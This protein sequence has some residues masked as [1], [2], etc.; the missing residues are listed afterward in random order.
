[1]CEISWIGCR[2]GTEAMATRGAVAV[3]DAIY[4]RYSSE[5][6]NP[7]SCDDQVTELR[8]ALERRGGRFDE[9]LVFRDAEVS[10]GVWQRDGLQGLLTAVEAGRVR[11]VFVEDVSRLSRDKEDAARL[12]KTFDYHGVSI[13][14]LD[15]MTYDGSVGASLAFTFQSA[16]AAQYLRDLGAKT[17][18]GLRG[19]HRAGK[20]TGGRCYGYDVVNRSIEI[21]HREAANDRRFFRLYLEGHGYAVIAQ[22]LDAL[23]VPAPRSRRRAGSG[24]MHT[25]IREMLRNPKYAGEFTFGVRK[26]QRHPMTRKRVARANHDAEVLRATRPELAIVD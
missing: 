1:M 12:E 23:G 16:G 4:A 22:K 17:R 7:R 21:N 11:R 8:Q 3:G 15:G 14:T 20:S 5:L 9:H 19:A 13:V 25:C 10:G 18:R 2:R 24:W 6:Q 26:W